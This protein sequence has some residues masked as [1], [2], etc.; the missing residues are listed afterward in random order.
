MDDSCVSLLSSVIVSLVLSVSSCTSADILF[1]VIMLMSMKNWKK[2]FW[3]LLSILENLWRCCSATLTQSSSLPFAMATFGFYRNDILFNEDVKRQQRK[4]AKQ[5]NNQTKTKQIHNQILDI[6]HVWRVDPLSQLRHVDHGMDVILYILLLLYRWHIKNMFI[7]IVMLTW[8]QICDGIRVHAVLYYLPFY[9]CTSYTVTNQRSRFIYTE[10]Q[11]Y[12]V[13]MVAHETKRTQ[14]NFSFSAT[15]F[16]H[17]RSFFTLFIR[18]FLF[19][20]CVI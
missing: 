8:A 11:F 12:D 17:L 1:F 3:K 16:P 20:C 19:V 13:E 6:L 18:F 9:S 4:K 7:F 2:K 10:I 14:E 15:F 5:T